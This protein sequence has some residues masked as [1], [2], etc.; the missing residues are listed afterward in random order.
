MIR[1]VDIDRISDGRRYRSGDLAKLGC[2]DCRDCFACCMDMGESIVLDPYDV[3]MMTGELNK[4]FVEL[5]G[6]EVEL[7]TCDGV[8]LPHIK[9]GGIINKCGF[10]NDEGRCGIYH[11]RPGICR[12]FPLGRIYEN[13]GFSYYLQVEECL[14]KNRT[15]VKIE[16][17]LGIPDLKK[18]EEYV[19]SWHDFIKHFGAELSEMEDMEE[20]REVSM[21]LIHFFFLTPYDPE[22]DFYSQFYERLNKVS[23]AE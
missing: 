13:G 12:L 22:R 19:L 3:Y 6:K 14:K 1:N 10:L 20:M 9:M 23:F 16:R 11:G 15:K 5:L 2:D 4:P 8:V 18:Y 7:G 17:W 21:M